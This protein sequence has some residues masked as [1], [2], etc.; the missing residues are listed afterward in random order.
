LGKRRLFL[1]NALQNGFLPISMKF[2]RLICVG[3]TVCLLIGIRA[4]G[5]T[6]AAE[7][8]SDSSW[9]STLKHE[10]DVIVDT[11]DRP[12]ERFSGRE[13]TLFVVAMAGSAGWLALNRRRTA[14]G[15]GSSKE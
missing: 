15:I 11:K 9:D 3:L 2:V 13:I 10:S 7:R 5:Q 14:A 1:D 12:L 4:S 8:T 6:S